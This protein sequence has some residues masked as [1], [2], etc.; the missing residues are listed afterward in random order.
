LT[1]L[2]ES[3]K[4]ESPNIKINRNS[5]TQLENAYRVVGMQAII[6]VFS[7]LLLFYLMGREAAESAFYGGMVATAN[8]LVLLRR[9]KLA[10][11]V[12]N[13]VPV[14]AMAVLYSSAIVRFVLVLSLFG[15]AFGVLHLQVLPAL[16]VFALAQLTYGWGLRKSYKELL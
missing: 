1:L 13:A 12:V 9:V 15:V 3:P 10:T 5:D 14:R 8:G 7:A 16:I 6:A 11:Q 4:I 2:K